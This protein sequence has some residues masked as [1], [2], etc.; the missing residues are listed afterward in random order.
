[1][2]MLTI[3]DQNVYKQRKIDF[4]QNIGLIFLFS[5]FILNIIYTIFHAI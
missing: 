5:L 3:N 4:L 1:M 2:Y